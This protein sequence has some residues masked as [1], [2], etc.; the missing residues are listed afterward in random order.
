ML[1][2]HC[3]TDVMQVAGNIYKWM[4]QI[5]TYSHS[6]FHFPGTRTNISCFCKVSSTQYQICGG[7][8][9]ILQVKYFF[10][11]LQTAACW[12]IST[13]QAHSVWQS[14]SDSEFGK[15]N[16]VITWRTDSYIDRE[17]I[18]NCHKSCIVSQHGLT[19]SL[20]YHAGKIPQMLD[21]ALSHPLCVHWIYMML[22]GLKESF[23]WFPEGHPLKVWSC[24]TLNMLNI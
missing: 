15:R 7:E 1:Q 21:Y 11:L 24:S 8:K 12:R 20:Q 4:L 17:Q 3:T 5:M 2:R 14:V 19:W 18:F 10:P 13:G 9:R 6:M 16:T 22:A 23:F